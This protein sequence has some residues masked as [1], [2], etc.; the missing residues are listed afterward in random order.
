MNR[1]FSW[2][3]SQIRYQLALVCRSEITLAKNRRF[4]ITIIRC[5][6]ITTT[7]VYSHA[8]VNLARKRIILRKSDNGTRLKTRERLEKRENV[9]IKYYIIIKHN[10]PIQASVASSPSDCR[11]RRWRRRRLRRS[12]VRG[13]TR[14]PIRSFSVFFR[15]SGLTEK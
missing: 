6:C 13:N 12:F 7:P 8:S 4:T 5:H 11:R 1:F 3:T 14:R 9:I 10:I 2:Q 15:P